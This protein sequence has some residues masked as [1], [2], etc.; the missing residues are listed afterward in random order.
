MLM[1]ELTI[2]DPDVS[3]ITLIKA[4]STMSQ[5]AD[6]KQFFSDRIGELSKSMYYLALRLTKN[7]ADAEDL[8][9]ETVVK[10]WSALH[11]LED[12]LHFRQWIFRILHNRFVSDYRKKSIRPLELSYQEE[13]SDDP[14]EVVNLL[15]EQ[16]NEFLSWW[17][18]PEREFVKNLL[19]ED[20]INAIDSLP[21]VFRTT[22]VLIS[23]EGL[24]YDDAA[25]VL[26]VPP[27]TVRSRIRRGRTLLQK[28]L[29][30]QAKDAGLISDSDEQEKTN[31]Q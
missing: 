16:P 14:V 12:K 24:S 27:G 5:Q 9:A 18:N 28:M 4:A 20:I 6:I 22:I 3:A 13:A 7:S 25:T 11:T 23:V 31:E 21:E 10:A 15:I 1:P 8:V 2:S 30:E 17:G 29:W 19:A 26:A